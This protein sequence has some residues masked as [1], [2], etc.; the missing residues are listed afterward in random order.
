MNEVENPRG[1]GGEL[2]GQAAA[3]GSN[4]LNLS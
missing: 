3:A 4:F 1:P 2:E